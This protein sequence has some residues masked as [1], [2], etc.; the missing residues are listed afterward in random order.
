MWATVHLPTRAAYGSLRVNSAR[1]PAVYESHKD[2]KRASSMQT[3]TTGVTII[4]CYMLCLMSAREMSEATVSCG[5][6]DHLL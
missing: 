6:D 3:D 4:S 2:A 1:P 5:V